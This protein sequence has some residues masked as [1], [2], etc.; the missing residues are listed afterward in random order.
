MLTYNTRDGDVVDDIVFRHYGALN[1]DMLR[2]VFEAN[3]GLADLG[4]VLP[5][6]VAIALPDIVQPA[7]LSKG[8]A[9]WD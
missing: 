8:V 5:P 4:P 7:G 6:N 3:R 2:Q 1:P 9:L